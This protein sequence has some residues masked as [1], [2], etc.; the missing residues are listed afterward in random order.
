M[1]VG[2]EQRRQQTE[3]HHLGLEWTSG[4]PGGTTPTIPTAIRASGAETSSRSASAVTASTAATSATRV[5]TSSTPG[6]WPPGRR[7]RWTRL[8]H[9]AHRVSPAEV[10]D[11]E[12]V[13]REHEE[14]PAVRR[15]GQHVGDHPAVGEHLGRIAER[16]DEDVVQP[17]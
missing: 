13:E 16:I 8:G 3:Q 10:G 15:E 2:V 14:R 1:A 12:P 6:L 11:P 9:P 5:M 7:V 4:M 17:P